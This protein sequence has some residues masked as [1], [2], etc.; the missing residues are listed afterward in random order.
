MRL[1]VRFIFCSIFSIILSG[2]LFAKDGKKPDYIIK[3][4][5]LPDGTVIDFNLFKSE[6]SLNDYWA[7]LFWNETHVWDQLRPLSEAESKNWY[8]KR[9]GIEDEFHILK[10]CSL[11]QIGQA[12]QIM[13]EMKLPQGIVYIFDGNEMTFINIIAEKGFKSFI[14]EKAR[15]TKERTVAENVQMSD[16]TKK[17]FCLF[18]SRKT[19]KSYYLEEM[20]RGQQWYKKATRDLSSK[21]IFS[22]DNIDAKIYVDGLIMKPVSQRE[23]GE[24]ADIMVE[25]R[26]P[27]AVTVE[28]I[29]SG[30]R[31]I[32]VETDDDWRI[33]KYSQIDYIDEVEWKAQNKK[34]DK[35]MR[36]EIKEIYGD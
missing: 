16:G 36:Q 15:S 5:E 3:D 21:Q 14:Y 35:E 19:I 26:M 7:D 25:K 33:F 11:E 24:L 17:S 13:K 23:I 30:R 29:G 9:I 20:G 6:K 2:I 18:R 32:T 34:R 12:G 1:T 8:K 4:C 22:M 28:V 10:S 31:V 27:A